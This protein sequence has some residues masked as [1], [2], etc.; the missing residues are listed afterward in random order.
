MSLFC[1][2]FLGDARKSPITQDGTNYW[3]KYD[4]NKS[5]LV[6]SITFIGLSYRTQARDC[7][8][9]KGAPNNSFTINS[10]LITDGYLVEEGVKWLFIMESHFK[11][12]LQF[13]YA[14][15]SLRSLTVR[16]GCYTWN[17]R[18]ASPDP[19]PRK[20]PK[21]SL[22]MTHT[23][24]LLYCLALVAMAAEARQE[25]ASV[26]EPRE[27]FNKTITA[28]STSASQGS[29]SLYLLKTPVILD[30]GSL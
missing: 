2:L 3:P 15:A 7:S 20:G 6:R 25:K 10:S 14:R 28:G 24:L 8:R 26:Y 18:Q 13:L 30:E 29:L 22:L 1:Q 21:T 11:F 16:R 17:P 4:C 19:P 5:S 9:I 27:K 23:C 12:T